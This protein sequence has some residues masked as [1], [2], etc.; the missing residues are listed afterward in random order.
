[1]KSRSLEQ[2]LFHNSLFLLSR[3]WEVVRVDELHGVEVAGVHKGVQ[4]LSVQVASVHE[5]VQLLSG[6][7]NGIQL[8]CLQFSGMH[9]RAKDRR[10]KTT[11]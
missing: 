6:V 2:K 5:C 11:I 10:M 3:R 9:R 4:L 1:M 8:L 7:H